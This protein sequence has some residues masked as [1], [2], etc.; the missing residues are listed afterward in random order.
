[1]TETNSTDLLSIPDEIADLP[2]SAKLVHYT[3][4]AD[5]SLTLQ[6]IRDRTKLPDQTARDAID[7]LQD[8]GLVKSMPNVIDA[9]QELFWL[10]TDD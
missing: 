8:Q 7:Q 6:A 5:G 2:P 1:M 9:R 10:A 4:Q 3:L